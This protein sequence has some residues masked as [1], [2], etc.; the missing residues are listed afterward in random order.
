[1]APRKTRIN[2]L[3]QALNQQAEAD[4]KLERLLEELVRL[5]KTRAALQQR[6]A[7]LV[8]RGQEVPNRRRGAGPR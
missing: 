5:L 1:M 2:L 7:A 6:V 3:E 4:G 8:A